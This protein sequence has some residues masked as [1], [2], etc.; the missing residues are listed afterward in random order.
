MNKKK[1]TNPLKYG[2]YSLVCMV[3]VLA[4]IIIANV[5]LSVLPSK[6]TMITNNMEGL[7]DISETS[8]KLGEKLE[9]DITVYVIAKQDQDND[10][11]LKI[12]EYVNRYKEISDRISVK[13]VDP[14]LRPGFVSAYTN[15][16]LDSS[17]THLIIV[18][19]KTDRSYVCEYSDIITSEK[20][21]SL[22]DE[23]Q[24][25]Y[26]LSYGT[27]KYVSS[28]NVENC[29]IAG[30]TYVTMEKT[31]TVYLTT[32]HGELGADELLSQLLSLSHINVGSVDLAL[33]GK[34]PSDVETLIIYSPTSDFAKAEIDLLKSFVRSG[35][36]VVLCSGYDHQSQN[37]VLSNLYS[38]IEE[39]YGMKYKDVLVF[40]G[41]TDYAYKSGTQYIGY[42]IYVQPKNDLKSVISSNKVIF[43]MAH[44]IEFSDNLPSGVTVKELLTTTEK[45]YAKTSFGADTVLDKVDGDLSGSF[46]LGAVSEKTTDNIT[47]KC[48]WF[49]SEFALNLDGTYPS[50]ANI[51]IP[52]HI[53]SQTVTEFDPLTVDSA[54]LSIIPLNF[55]ESSAKIWGAVFIGIIPLSILAVGF[56]VR[57]RRTKR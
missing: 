57:Y 30:I 13:T 51:Y 14:E 17:L 5:A 8:V 15:T 43:S 32:G 3:I 2:T 18:N 19:D 10:Y 53:L 25:Y 47:S 12:S 40:E 28:F 42:N 56:T 52:V 48:M 44:A 35:G 49:S 9:D 23:E 24:Y 37:R 36:N 27:Y 21:P 26:Y 33:D 22:S 20:D 41:N 7:Y 4:I 50:Y 16:A 39:E 31:P 1:L 55:S 6:Y 11:H 46:I 34:I 29:L 54:S 38:F 45:G